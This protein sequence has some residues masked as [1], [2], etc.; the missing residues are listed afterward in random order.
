MGNLL[1]D[2]RPIL[3]IPELAVII[4]GWEAAILQQIH[5]WLKINEQTD[6]NYINGFHWTFNTYESWQR[7]LPWLSV[8]TIKRCI[9][10]L[11]KMGL[12][13]SDNFNSLKVDK[14]KWYRIDHERLEA[15][16]ADHAKS[17][18]TKVNYSEVID[19]ALQIQEIEKEEKRWSFGR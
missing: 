1:L 7:Q 9:L 10:K 13:V 6:R 11:E 2:S 16:I 5:Y 12:L 19:L 17:E 15:L 14:T 8:E 3:I 18:G 4:G